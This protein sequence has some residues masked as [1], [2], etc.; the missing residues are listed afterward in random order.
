[1]KETKFKLTDENGTVHNFTHKFDPDSIFTHQHKPLNIADTFKRIPNAKKVEVLGL[2]FEREQ[3]NL[4][5]IYSPII[6]SQEYNY[7]SGEWEHSTNGIGG[8]DTKQK[9]QKAIDE[10]EIEG[11][12]TNAYIETY[13]HVKK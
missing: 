8:Y 4:E 10:Y 6:D 7:D 3:F 2:E 5:K 11:E 1:M 12:I 9:A 13:W